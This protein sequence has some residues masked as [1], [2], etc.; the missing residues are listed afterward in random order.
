M[1]NRFL[2]GLVILFLLTVHCSST[3][4]DGHPSGAVTVLRPQAGKPLPG[5]PGFVP[6]NDVKRPGVGLVLSG[7][8]ARG[9]ASIG[10][11]KA[12]EEHDIP[13]DLI[14]GTSIGSIVGG[15][16]ASGYTPAELERIATSADWDEVLSYDDDARR[17]DMFLDQKLATDKSILVLRFDGFEPVIPASYST[18]QRLMN[19]L[20]L[21]VLQA[22]YRPDPSFDALRVPFR[23]VTTDLISGNQYVFRR[24]DLSEALRAAVAV[25]LLFSTVQK[26]SMQLLDG[27]L[28]SNMPVEVA[29]REGMEYIIV[30][31][32]TSPLRPASQV[33]APWEIGEQIMGIMMQGPNREAR[34]KADVLITP[35][36]GDHLSSDFTDIEG[37]IASGYEAASSVI[38][39]IRH[40]LRR[41][42]NETNGRAIGPIHID[43]ATADVDPED[44]PL[45]EPLRNGSI[46]QLDALQRLV[47]ALHQTGRYRDLGVEIHDT[48]STVTLT[49]VASRYPVLRSVSFSGV[50]SL[51][52]DS[53]TSF[54][55]GQVGA[56]LNARAS[57]AAIER[58][59]GLYRSDGFS[60]AHIERAEFTEGTGEAHLRIDE[61]RI[62]R[63]TIRGTEKTRDYVVWRELPFRAGDVFR[64][65][66][67]AQ[68]LSNLYSTSLFEQASVTVEHEGPGDEQ[69][70]VVFNLK[71]RATGLIRLG[72]QVDN[73]RT[74]QPWL[75]MRDENFMGA[76]AEVGASFAGGTRNQSVI[77]ELKAPRIF[78]SY[79]TSRLRVYYDSRDVNMFASVPGLPKDRFERIRVGEIREI[80]RG[81]SLS[82]G[83][84]LE[85]LGDVTV[86]GRLEAVKVYNIVN[87]PITNEDYNIS[88]IRFG[89]RVDTQDKVP[90]PSRGVNLNFSYETALVRTAT[91]IG[92]TK[93]L[94]SYESF[95]SY[96]GAHTLSP[97]IMLGLGDDA[98]PTSE[99]FSLGGQHSFFGFREDNARGR[100]IIVG[101]LEYRYRLPIRVAFDAYVSL[102]YDIGAVW[103][104]PDE[105]RLVDMQHGIGI[106]LGFDTPIGPAQFSI[107]RSFITRGDLLDQPLALGP[108][109]GY[110]SIGYALH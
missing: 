28:I 73:E 8:G 81:G 72:L 79:L 95:R 9:L 68:G 76:G 69:H 31:D 87:Q 106:G 51:P 110:F 32:V 11:L 35:S 86:E 54:F 19:F 5:G 47:N 78:D 84:Q 22:I 107:G 63:M 18:G 53:L 40:Q 96:G 4:Q 56:P 48:D 38:D 80:R 39:E 102:R 64:V 90:F 49:L 103:L 85:R 3:A 46:V 12:F 17:T 97:R 34:E 50:E 62:A 65:S 105:I 52:P 89:T 43:R 92:F 14:V 26:D 21:L 99:Q 57:H 37:L 6:F 33:V 100:Q 29:E 109:L 45:L 66:K 71:E 41:S 20:N 83:T 7:G 94:F 58:I 104:R 27:G 44:E 36:L 82:F 15:L 1:M 88:S 10:V 60:L 77:G 61:G 24:G 101:G 74:F 91:S 23:A 108:V 70:I 42:V 25:P 2:P 59:L 67:I 75:N 30:V 55:A 16:Y 98:V 13:I 93:F